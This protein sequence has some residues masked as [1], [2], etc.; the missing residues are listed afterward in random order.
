M[1]TVA[2]FR[3]GIGVCVCVF[4]GAS[5]VSVC[6][7]ALNENSSVVRKYKFSEGV[8]ISLFPVYVIGL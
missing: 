5:T 6:A 4:I 3:T 2:D 1:H 8:H 7:R